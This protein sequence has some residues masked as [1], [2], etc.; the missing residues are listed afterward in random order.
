MQDDFVPHNGLGSMF[1]IN[2]INTGRLSPTRRQGGGHSFKS[3]KTDED[4]GSENS[5]GNYLANTPQSQKR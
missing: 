3:N 4:M 1:D 5:A 2:S